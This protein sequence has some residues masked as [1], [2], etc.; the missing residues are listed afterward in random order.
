MEP[1]LSDWRQS[2]KESNG[3]CPERLTAEPEGVEWVPHVAVLSF[4]RLKAQL[5]RA[6]ET[7]VVATYRR[8]PGLR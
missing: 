5:P 6:F 1:A 4:T 8:V 2:R 3:A 7:V